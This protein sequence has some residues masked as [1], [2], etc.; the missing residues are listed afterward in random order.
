MQCSGQLLCR[1]KLAAEYNWSIFSFYMGAC[2]LQCPHEVPLHVMI[3]T[4]QLS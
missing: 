3:D 4:V 2:I 1:R